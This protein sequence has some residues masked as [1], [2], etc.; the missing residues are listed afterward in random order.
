VVF[1]KNSKGRVGQRQVNFFTG[2]AGSGGVIVSTAMMVYVYTATKLSSDSVYNNAKFGP[3]AEFSG[4]S[5]LSDTA[6]T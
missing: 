5:D 4:N 1:F 3:S 2:Q 6:F